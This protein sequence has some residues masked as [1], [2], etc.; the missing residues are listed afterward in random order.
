MFRL[1]GIKIEEYRGLQ[2]LEIELAETTVLIGENN[3]GKTSVLAAL[4]ACLG[5]TARR[6]GIS[7]A[8]YDHRRPGSEGELPD[9]HT[10][11]I[12]LRFYED[13]VDEWSDDVSS[14]LS[15]VIQLDDEDKRSIVMRV[16]D[17]YDASERTFSPSTSF[18]NL[19]GRD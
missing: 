5:Q 2:S 18:L 17:V 1:R 13:A 7:F 10:L 8:D 16:T 6:R 14:A 3:V 15:D 12:T 11:T 9:G 4:D 19:D